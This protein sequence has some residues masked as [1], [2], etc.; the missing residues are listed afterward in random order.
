LDLNALRRNFILL[1]RV[2]NEFAVEVGGVPVHLSLLHS[3]L[4]LDERVVARVGQACAI[5]ARAS[6]EEMHLSA[7]DVSEGSA[8]VLIE[9]PWDEVVVAAK[10]HLR[11][12]P[13]V[14]YTM[15]CKLWVALRAHLE[16]VPPRMN[17]LQSRE[18]DSKTQQVG[19]VNRVR[20]GGQHTRA[21]AQEEGRRAGRR[22]AQE[23]STHSKRHSI[24]DER[25]V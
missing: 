6:L 10:V 20:T 19:W 21:A 9:V 22:A 14:F 11:A 2:A 24:T 18:R 12:A 7:C 23:G 15:T 3:V 8:N 4:Q 16:D 5:G 25:I 17:S 13:A 1:H